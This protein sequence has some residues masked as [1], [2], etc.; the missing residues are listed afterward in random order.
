M[1]PKSQR[2]PRKDFAPLLKSRA[3]Y[4]SAHFTLRYA[5]N[6]SKTGRATASVSK[7]ISKRAVVRNTVRRRIY[8]IL[9][10]KPLPSGLFLFIAKAGADKVKGE[11]LKKEV[12][13]LLKSAERSYNS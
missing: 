8:S 1:L 9:A 5:E 11:E 3:F 10:Q 2:I 6:G 12:L 13:D 7:K 4:N